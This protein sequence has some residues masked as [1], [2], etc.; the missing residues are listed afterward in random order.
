M[1][2]KINIT[3][4]QTGTI[5]ASIDISD[6][7]DVTFPNNIIVETGTIPVVVSNLAELKALTKRPELLE[8]LGY[9]NP[10]DGGNGIFRWV[11]SDVSTAD[12]GL[13]I[14]CTSGPS[15]RY[16]RIWSN[17]I[18]AKWFGAKF[19]G[20]TNDTVPLTRFINA[21][22]ANSPL[23]ATMPKG[24]AL[25][26]SPLPNINTMGIS[27]YGAGPSGNHDI[28]TAQGTVLRYTGVA[29]AT[30]LT[31]A[32]DSNPS[33]QRLTGIKFIG[34][35]LDCNNLAAKGLSLKSCAY[36]EFDFTV[37][38]PTS[39]G[40]DINV[41]AS[42]GEAKDVFRNRIR[43][44]ARCVESPNGIALVIG[45]DSVANTCFNNFEYIDILHLNNL[46]IRCDNSDNNYWFDIRSYSGG[47]LSTNSMEFRGGP[48]EP[49]SS[50]G[51][52]I[53]K[54]STDKPIIVKGTGT[55]AVGSNNHKIFVL[56][57]ENSSPDPV[58]ENG[59]TLSWTDN[60]NKMRPRR[61]FTPTISADVPGNGVFQLVE[62]RYSI[63]EGVCE[64]D[65]TCH[66][67][68]KGTSDGDIIITLP[69]LPMYAASV[70]GFRTGDG[71]ALI[72]NISPG[73]LNLRMGL[74]NG[75]SPIQDGQYYNI[76]FKYEVA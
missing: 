24:I 30:M 35:T 6:I 33:N 69:L 5:N 27:L 71:V 54:I 73:N 3:D 49:L 1:S 13:I 20:T 38:N 50:R 18:E 16:K 46:S 39:I 14:Q 42:L 76:T 53:F 45:G 26:T 74:Y 23:F 64:G 34:I 37:Y 56:D 32:P 29:G 55:Y 28:G 65:V 47:G 22:L 36:S 25:I 19:D 59:A 9:Y 17:T 58:V 62:S 40:F 15:G 2:N 44:T 60:K 4:S 75:L 72:G 31:I 7:G 66:V 57:K 63:I 61:T 52:T 8:M 12:D 41:V 43:Y 51:E 48:S 11:A 67:V 21:V 10:G 68:T 70:A